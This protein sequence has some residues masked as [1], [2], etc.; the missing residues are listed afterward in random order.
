MVAGQKAGKEVSD[1]YVDIP[2]G[3]I[4]LEGTLSQPDEGGHYAGVV[5]CHPH[6][7]R[8][9]DMYNNV[10]EAVYN[11][12]TAR[13]IIALRFNFRGVG[14]SGG[15][16]HD[17]SGH[18]DDIGAAIDYLLT[19]KEVDPQHIGLVGYS[20]GAA[21]VLH[22]APGDERLNAIAVVS[23]A[24]T[25]AISDPILK[26]ERPKYFLSGERDG[27]VTQKKFSNLINSV[28]EPKQYRL[29][30][31]ADHFWAGYEGAMADDVATFLQKNI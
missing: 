1:T 28:A 6:P 27:I 16:A 23:P 18:I 12:L 4:I 26:Y 20:Y 2:C 15:S 7:L 11:E 24:M 21:M 31:G 8:G 29:A 17:S 22:Y 14:S 3:D 10:V 5:I 30:A 19:L 9:G 13:Q 25:P